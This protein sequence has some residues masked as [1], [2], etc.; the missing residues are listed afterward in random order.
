MRKSA[1]VLLSVGCLTGVLSAP[2]M[3]PR[4]PRTAPPVLVTPARL[5]T[6]QAAFDL[7]HLRG[8]TIFAYR[9]DPSRPAPDVF[10]WEAGT[11]RLLSEME[12]AEN[13]RALPGDTTVALVGG[14]GVLSPSLEAAVMAIAPKTLRIPT[15]QAVDLFNGLDD[16]CRFTPR[17][18]K[19][20]A[21]RYNLTLTDEN[22]SRRNYNPY[23][24]RQ[25]ELP[26]PK[27]GFPVADDGLPPADIELPS[28]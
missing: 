14:P 21:E 20:L 4:P 27:E 16:V 9:A 13:L 7:Q 25:S 23:T 17:E 8:V 6:V 1:L 22:E 3:A 28:K 12:F 15:L 2:A 26:L 19:R 24:V 18:W 11:W 5:R 10:L